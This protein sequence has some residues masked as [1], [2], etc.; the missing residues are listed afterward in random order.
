MKLKREAKDKTI[1]TTKFEKTVNVL[2][3]AEISI[4]REY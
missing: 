3:Q 4:C 2:I 1:S